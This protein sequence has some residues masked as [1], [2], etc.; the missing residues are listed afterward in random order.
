MTAARKPCDADKVQLQ[1]LLCID[2]KPTPLLFYLNSNDVAAAV[3]AAAA[4]KHQCKFKKKLEGPGE[5][6]LQSAALRSIQGAPNCHSHCDV[7]DDFQV[8]FNRSARYKTN[9]QLP[10]YQRNVTAKPVFGHAVVIV[11]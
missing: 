7:Q 1:C 3:T 8:Q 10:P 4:I 11:G 2:S 9:D 5:L 6:L